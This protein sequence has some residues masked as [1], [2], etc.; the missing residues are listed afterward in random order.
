MGKTKQKKVENE[1]KSVKPNKNEN[2]QS[3]SALVF[4]TNF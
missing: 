2:N 3:V 4:L 1:Q